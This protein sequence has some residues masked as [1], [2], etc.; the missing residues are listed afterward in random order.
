ML[1]CSRAPISCRN[2]ALIV[3]IAAFAGSYYVYKDPRHYRRRLLSRLWFLICKRDLAEAKLERELLKEPEPDI[4]AS[5]TQYVDLNGHR[6]RIVH[7]IHELGSRVPLLVF[8]HGLGGQVAQ[9]QYQLEYFSQTAHVLAIDLLG[10]GKS[11]LSYDWDPYTTASLV[12]DVISLLTDRY[13]YPSTVIIAHAYGC[14]I[15]T[16]VAA[17]PLIQPS[18]RGLVLISPKEHID[19]SQKKSKRN[20][21]WIPDWLFE[22]AWT[23]DRKGGLYSKSVER[24]LG[25]DAEDQLRRNQLRWNLL[26]RTSTYKR[27]V[28]GASFPPPTVYQ[29]IN[30]GVL[31]IS[32][33][34]DKVTPPNDVNII[35][36]HLLGLDPQDMN[37]EHLS[38]ADNIRVP[39]PY[40][41]PDVGHM[42]MVVHPELVNPVIS[43]FLIKNC[44]LHTLSGA[45]QVL[46]KTKGENKWDLKNYEKWSRTQCITAG[47]IG[48]SLFRAMK[49]MRQTDSAHCPSG[50]LAKYP[51]IGFII[52]ISNDTPPYRAS[53]FEHSRIEYIKLRTVSKIPPERDD[54]AKFIEVASQCWEKKPDA[55]IAVHCH[56]GFNRTGFFICC[57][58]IERLGVSVPDALR[59]F[60][61]ARPPGIRH[62]HFVDELYLRYVLPA[63]SS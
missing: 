11:E 34:E 27:F 10:C 23:A 49:V 2:A 28:F 21:R 31:L 7:I 3:T 63:R 9:W 55:Q 60:A 62:A 47:P 45:W 57:Y 32:G 29:K 36:N 16:H 20:L 44:G 48:P 59:Y 33:S 35:H 40:V 26:N 6:L 43:E 19:D 13:Q 25:F 4:I 53:D 15:A 22:C 38:H 54:V 52:D 1:L 56:Y 46:H 8:I 17:S 41:I 37:W 18:L 24:L 39:E 14:S 5:H 58:M 42:P 50:F 51:E 61:D 30:V 12:N